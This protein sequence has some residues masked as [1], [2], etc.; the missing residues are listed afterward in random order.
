MSK[1][2]KVYLQ[3][4]ADIDTPLAQ[5]LNRLKESSVTRSGEAAQALINYFLPLVYLEQS[6]LSKQEQWN[7][8]QSL[9]GLEQQLKLYKYFYYGTQELN[10]D[11]VLPQVESVSIARTNL[12]SN[13][14]NDLS[15]NNEVT[16]IDDDNFS[17]CGI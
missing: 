15:D 10:F 1:K 12:A 7:L 6:S 8:M 2:N 17:D 3:I 13:T 4:I 9:M 14:I 5:V 16:E 11:V